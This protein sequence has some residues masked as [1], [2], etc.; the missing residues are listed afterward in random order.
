LW[1][2]CYPGFHPGLFSFAPYGSNG[3]AWTDYDN[4]DLPHGSLNCKPLISRSE[5][6]ATS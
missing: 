3:E 1:V 2:I 5:A 6:G 4:H